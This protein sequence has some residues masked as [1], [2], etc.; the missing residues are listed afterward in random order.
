MRAGRR[1]SVLLD[2]FIA[3][4]YAVACDFGDT[5]ILASRDRKSPV[6]CV[7][8]TGESLVDILGRLGP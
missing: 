8:P 7:E 5:R 4:Q 3:R 2:G 1:G 6:R